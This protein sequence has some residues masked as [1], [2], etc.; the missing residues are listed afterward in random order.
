MFIE[1]LKSTTASGIPKKNK[2]LRAFGNMIFTVIIG[3]SSLREVPSI[4]L[5]CEGKINHLGLKEFHK[6]SI[7]SDSNKRRSSKN[8]PIFINCSRNL[9]VLFRQTS[10]PL[11][12]L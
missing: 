4:M 10:E 6:R 5:T 7:I 2:Y 3:F 11:S 9:D 8:L 12:Q 1:Q